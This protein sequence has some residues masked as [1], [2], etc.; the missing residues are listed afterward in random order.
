MPYIHSHHMYGLKSL[1][2][3]SA[4]YEGTVPQGRLI[5]AQHEVLGLLKP[6]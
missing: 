6:K 1:R 4:L 3:N 5:L 2:D